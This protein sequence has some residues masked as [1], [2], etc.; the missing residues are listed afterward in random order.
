MTLDIILEQLT[1]D[2]SIG[3]GAKERSKRQPIVIDITCRISSAPNTMHDQIEQTL[4][5]RHLYDRIRALAEGS[6][7]CLLETLAQKISEICFEDQRVIQVSIRVIKP[8]K[9]AGCEAVGVVYTTERKN[10]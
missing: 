4:N 2:L 6:S 10:S 9:F 8:K 3:I 1:L 7:F 5:Y